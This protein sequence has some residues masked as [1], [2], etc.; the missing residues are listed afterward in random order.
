MVCKLSCVFSFD[1][2]SVNRIICGA[3]LRKASSGM[4]EYKT[5]ICL[6]GA[7]Q[8]FSYMVLLSITVELDHRNHICLI[9]SMHNL[10][11]IL[12]PTAP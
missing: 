9:E 1:T 8:S 5:R 10:L 4:Q 3:K 12:C 6:M 7:F 11:F 2:K